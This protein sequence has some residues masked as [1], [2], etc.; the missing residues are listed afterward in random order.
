MPLLTRLLRRREQRAEPA[1]VSDGEQI[2]ISPRQGNDRLRASV[3][4]SGP[5]TLTLVLAPGS[6]TLRR[7]GRV[8]LDWIDGVSL[9]HARGRVVSTRAGPP[10]VVEI[11]LK[12]W[13]EAVERRGQLRVAAA[14]DVS[15][16]SLQDP[17]RLLA[18]RTV[19]LSEGGALLQLPLMPETASTLD[20]RI[21]LPDGA[22]AALAHVVRRA[23]DDLV[24]V[25][26][27]PKWPQ[28]RDRLASFVAARLRDA[29][30]A[31]EPL[32]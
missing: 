2:W 6:P 26:L 9:V 22:L 20:L 28:E 4:T 32:P 18:G 23:L 5:G 31:R 15:G 1:P 19:D 21:L 27:E 3:A 11:R 17:T 8:E 13:P 7:R 24:A 12:G 29:G 14:L 10:P 25:R 30:V 16:W